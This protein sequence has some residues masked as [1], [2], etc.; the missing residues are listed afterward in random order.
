MRTIVSHL[1][2]FKNNYHG[3]HKT[4]TYRM[5]Q[6]QNNTQYRGPFFYHLRHVVERMAGN[7]IWHGMAYSGPVFITVLHIRQ[8]LYWEKWPIFNNRQAR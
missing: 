3:P 6:L 1:N 2:Y 5:E 4:L 7:G 8:L